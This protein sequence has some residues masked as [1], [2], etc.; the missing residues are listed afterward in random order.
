MLL[1]VDGPEWTRL[2]SLLVGR[3]RGTLGSVVILD[4]R[5]STSREGR[6]DRGGF[7]R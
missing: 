2:E 5:D 1:E 3:A 6:C 7:L 4:G